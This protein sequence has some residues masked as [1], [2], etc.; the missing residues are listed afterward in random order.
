MLQIIKDAIDAREELAFNYSGISRVA[1]PV[2]VGRSSAGK[3]I[4]RC[5]QT[6]GGHVTAGHAWDLCQIS[7][8]SNVHG[9]GK[10]F[11]V[12]PPGYKRGDRHMNPIY[13]EI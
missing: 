6:E 8:M 2:A 12:N 7:L 4:L 9:T 5:Y 1:Q 13:T 3:D 11:S 10:T